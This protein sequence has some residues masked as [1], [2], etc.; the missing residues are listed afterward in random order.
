MAWWYRPHN[1]EFSNS[2]AT[3]FIIFGEIFP[4]LKK[5]SKSG[6][7]YG[8]M[9]QTPQWGIFKF[10]GHEIHHFRRNFSKDEGLMSANDLQE[11]LDS[12]NPED[13]KHWW[14]GLPQL[15][16]LNNTI[17]DKITSNYCTFVKIIFDFASFDTPPP[18]IDKKTSNREE[19]LYILYTFL[20]SLHLIPNNHLEFLK[21]R[22]QILLNSL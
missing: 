12:L 14:V 21:K 10:R 17:N 13:I 5:K 8:L 4:K 18:F 11:Y 15:L 22:P 3:K 6:H 16:Q 1:E 9:L 7:I 20:I 2:V 19:L